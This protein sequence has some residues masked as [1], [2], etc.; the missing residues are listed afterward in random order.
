MT[1]GRINQGAADILDISSAGINTDAVLARAER[2]RGQAAA[3]PPESCE[4]VEAA[5]SGSA[6]LTRRAVGR[7]PRG[8]NH[9]E[10]W[11][12]H[13]PT[14]HDAR[15]TARATRDDD[16]VGTRCEHRSENHFIELH[17]NSLQGLRSATGSPIS[18]LEHAS[19]YSSRPGVCAAC[20]LR[21]GGHG[22]PS[23]GSR[24]CCG[25]RTSP[26][27]GSGRQKRPPAAQTD[28]R[29]GYFKSR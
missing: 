18:W 26:E 25:S 15:A 16:Y 6:A 17:L 10:T 29:V 19:S 3:R 13:G 8:L 12:R 24:Q 23:A 21:T 28:S 1:T 11:P 14:R 22:G 5:W 2:A 7:T 4:R 27:I 20:E 9:A